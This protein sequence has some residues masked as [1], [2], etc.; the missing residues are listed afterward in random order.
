MTGGK[1]S[2]K[3][4]ASRIEVI[5]KL[6][7]QAGT[8]LRTIRNGQRRY[9]ELR[10]EIGQNTHSLVGDRS[11]YGKAEIELIASETGL[12]P[13]YL[14]ESRAFFLALPNLEQLQTWI[15]DR[16]DVSETV[17]WDRDVRGL[18]Y[19]RKSS[20]VNP[21]DDRLKK[22]QRDAERL[23][24]EARSV[25]DEARENPS[26]V[27]NVDEFQSIVT[28][29]LET[30]TTVPGEIV[31]QKDITPRSP[32]YKAFVKAHPCYACGKPGPV[33]PHHVERHGSDY[34]T[35][36]LCRECHGLVQDDNLPQMVADPYWELKAVA[37]MLHR[38][39]T[40]IQYAKEIPIRGKR[41]K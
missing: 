1:G 36:P 28:K 31:A 13:A 41:L 32:G 37:D 5:R 30:A 7:A 22:I 3:T 27:E 10:W 16:L 35:I 4:W 33:D 6:D 21:M 18:I 24:N 12:H 2:G 25:M 40:L 34:T 9:I 20:N 8:I 26:A 17:L 15:Q 19:D 38:W 14:R 11:D 23:E 39:A 29:A